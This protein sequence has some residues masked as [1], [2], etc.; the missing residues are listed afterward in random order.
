MLL[1]IYKALIRFRL[2][3]GGFLTAPCAKETINK[4]QQVQLMALR[5][6][7]GYRINT[8]SNVILA[9][10]KQLCLEN[11]FKYLAYRYF[12]KYLSYEDNLIIKELEHINSG[13]LSILKQPQ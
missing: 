3:Y 10:A 5:L 2:E 6:I 8:S 13:K 11:R 7:L 12:L 1:I 4:M 9:E